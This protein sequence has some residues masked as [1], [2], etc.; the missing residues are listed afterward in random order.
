MEKY[1][2]LQTLC[3]IGIAVFT[4]LLAIC[5]YGSYHFGEKKEKAKAINLNNVKDNED[6][7][8]AL[9]P[10]NVYHIKGDLVQGNK[11]SNEKNEVINA[12]EALIVTKNQSG[13]I[14]TV[15]V[16][17][18]EYKPIDD[19]VKKS[20][21][22]KLKAVSAKFPKAP[23]SSIE[24]EAGNTQRHKIALDLESLLANYQLGE[25]PKGNTFMGRFPENPISVFANPINRTYV[26][27]LIKSLGEF[28]SEG[29]VIVEDVNFPSSFIRI[30]INGQPLFDING[31]VKVQ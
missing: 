20:I 5:G 16:F 3:Q 1:Q 9:N 13:G 10:K 17:Q 31:K 14:N 29:F 15:N 12:P 22:E 6:N 26:D 27:E 25:Y 24:V 30:Y 18:N 21:S 8:T 19:K 28:I 2:T 11:V 23:I 4:I 7:D